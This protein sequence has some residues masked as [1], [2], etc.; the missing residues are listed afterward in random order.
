[1]EQETGM[2]KIGTLYKRPH[3]RGQIK[4]YTMCRVLRRTER[5]WL[6][7]CGDGCRD[8]ITEEEAKRMEEVK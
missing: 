5:G 7:D 3:H 8:V 6:I 4:S 1:M 2:L